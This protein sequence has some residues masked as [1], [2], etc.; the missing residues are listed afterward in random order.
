MILME[1]L[2]LLLLLLKDK[3]NNNHNLLVVEVEMREEMRENLVD[4]VEENKKEKIVTVNLTREFFYPRMEY[5][6]STNR[7]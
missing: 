6:S 1:I 4:E 7:Q 2:R 3:D 5:Y